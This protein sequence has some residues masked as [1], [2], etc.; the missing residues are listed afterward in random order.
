MG[1]NSGFKGL[2]KRMNIVRTL[3]NLINPKIY[4]I[5]GPIPFCVGMCSLCTLFFHFSKRN[6]RSCPE[7]ENSW[8]YASILSLEDWCRTRFRNIYRRV[9]KI[10]KSDYFLRHG[11]LSVRLTLCL[12]G[13][14]EELGSQRMDL[15]E[16][17]YFSIFENRW[18]KFR[19]HLKSDKNN[20]Y[21]KT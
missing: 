8:I 20:G 19:C 6:L 14:V 18:R 5:C 10:A 13:H 2:N 16:I 17:W 21:M 15:C 11:R 12:S 3:A 4:C 1:F 7:I 9:R